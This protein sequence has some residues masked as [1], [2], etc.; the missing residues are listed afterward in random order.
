MASYQNQIDEYRERR[1]NN[2]SNNV[3]VIDIELQNRDLALAR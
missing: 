1:V 2:G 3:S